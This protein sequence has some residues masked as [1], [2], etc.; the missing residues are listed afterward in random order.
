RN[1]N[2][3][4]VFFY[5]FSGEFSLPALSIQ[6]MRPQKI[7][8][9]DFQIIGGQTH[10]N[11]GRQGTSSPSVREK[12]NVLQIF[13]AFSDGLLYNHYVKLQLYAG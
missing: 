5:S 13:L 7:R 9:R 10:E 3:C 2:G 11:Y 1:C 8:R 4:G 12:S 6:N